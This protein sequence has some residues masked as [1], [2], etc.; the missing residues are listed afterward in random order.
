MKQLSVPTANNVEVV[1]NALVVDVRAL[2]EQRHGDFGVANA[3]DGS[4]HTGGQPPCRFCSA[5]RV[6]HYCRL[7]PR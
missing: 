1:V 5:L 3:L 2:L 4:G 6:E 7:H